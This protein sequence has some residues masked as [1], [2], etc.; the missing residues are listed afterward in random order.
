MP[1]I[2]H[3][4]EPVFP[5]TAYSYCSFILSESALLSNHLSRPYNFYPFY[6]YRV[7]LQTVIAVLLSI[8]YVQPQL[9]LRY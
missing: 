8:A 3:L 2:Y 9:H 7:L 4:D 5:H 1:E 6:L